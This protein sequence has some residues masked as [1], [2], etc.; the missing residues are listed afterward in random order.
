M[1]IV[2]EHAKSSVLLIGNFF[3][4]GEFC[5]LKTGIPGGPGCKKPR[6]FTKKIFKILILRFYFFVN[7][8]IQLV[9][10]NCCFPV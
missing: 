1:L 5:F 10:E 6:F 4:G 7:L 3:F 8:K 9:A 2:L